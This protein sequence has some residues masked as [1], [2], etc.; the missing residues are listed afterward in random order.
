MTEGVNDEPDF[1]YWLGLRH[2]NPTR[3]R[4]WED[5]QKAYGERL[6]TL[7]GRRIQS[8][9]LLWETGCNDW[10]ND[11]PVILDMGSTQLEICTNKVH[12]IAVSFDT[13]DT[14]QQMTWYR[15]ADDVPTMSFRWVE[16]PESLPLSEVSSRRTI[17]VPEDLDIRT[18]VGRRVENIAVG[19]WDHALHSLELYLDVG[20]FAVWNALDENGIRFHKPSGKLGLHQL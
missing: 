10:H 7:F 6:R 2:Y 15:D 20:H 8:V 17:L 5:L 3:F 12:E 4:R 18:V 19:T 16:N 14:S 13:I 9:W 1:N 11:G